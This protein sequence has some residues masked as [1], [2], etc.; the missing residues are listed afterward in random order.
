MSLIDLIIYIAIIAIA[1]IILWFLFTQMTLPEP[2]RQIVLIVA[3]V[4]IGVIAIGML[5]SM[6]GGG[7]FRLSHHSVLSDQMRVAAAPYPCSSQG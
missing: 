6:R 4:L 5:L 1:V 3:V 2:I 7:G